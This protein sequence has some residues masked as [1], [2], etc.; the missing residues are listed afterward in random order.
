[1]KK[2]ILIILLVISFS[3]ALWPSADSW[4]GETANNPKFQTDFDN[5]LGLEQAANQAGIKNVPFANNT[6][7]LAAVANG[8]GVA[9]SFLG[10]IFFGLVMFAGFTWMTA[11]GASEQVEKAKKLLEGAVIG[12]VL[13]LSS[14]AITN[15]V[16]SR[17]IGAPSGSSTTPAGSVVDCAKATVG[18]ICADNSVCDGKSACITKC[19]YEYGIKIQNQF[20][21][22][23]EKTAC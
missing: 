23:M 15:F 3:L 8:I 13:V 1:M 9:M 18:T 5:Y 11:A 14:Y 6:L 19:E 22:C 4:A 21:K 10:I 17:I 16:F 7:A 20:G 2:T 12:L